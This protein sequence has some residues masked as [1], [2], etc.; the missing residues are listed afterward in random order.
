MVI[1]FNFLRNSEKFQFFILIH[2]GEMIASRYIIN[3]QT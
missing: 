3:T 1:L 2:K